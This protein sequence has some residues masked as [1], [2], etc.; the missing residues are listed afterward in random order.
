MKTTFEDI[1][2]QLTTELPDVLQQHEAYLVSTVT[3]RFSLYVVGAS[4]ELLQQLRI[5]FGTSLDAIECI[6]ADGFIHQHLQPGRKSITKT[7]FFVNRPADKRNWFFTGER[8]TTNATTVAFYSFKGGLGR[9]TAL[10]LSALQ[11]A[12][13]G[14]R[15]ALIDF[16][17]EASGLGSLFLTDQNSEDSVQVQGVVDYLIDLA[18]NDYKANALDLASYYFTVNQQSLVGQEGGEL[19][20]FPATNEQPIGG[21]QATNY[22]DKLAKINLQFDKGQPYAPDTLIK[23]IRVFL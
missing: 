5:R 7:L 10:V 16:D 22:I 1:K 6:D 8:L 21:R 3:T 11:L 23:T 13:Q 12:R 9:T 2:N 15:V 4:D 18:A 19:L 20:V 17:L 14:K